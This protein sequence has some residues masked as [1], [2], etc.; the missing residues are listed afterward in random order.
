[1]ALMCPKKC[2]KGVKFTQTIFRK[3]SHSGNLGETVYPKFS[4]EPLCPVTC[5]TTYWIEQKLEKTVES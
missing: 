5:L 4:D 3:P 1:M 2:P